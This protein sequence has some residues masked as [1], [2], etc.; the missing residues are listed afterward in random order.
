MNAFNMILTP[1]IAD[2]YHKKNYKQLE[3][4]FRVNTKWGIYCVIPLVL[5]IMFA[6]GDIMT[7]LFGSEYS[8]GAVALQI[9][10]IG[11]FINIATGA[12]GIMLIMTGHQQEWFRLSVLIVI[13]NIILNL[14]LIPR[15]GIEGTAIAT[16]ST[17][18]GLFAL[19]LLIVRHTLHMWPYDRRY[20]KGLV[21]AGATVVALLLIA[22][23]PLSPLLNV[24]ISTA[25]SGIVFVGVLLLQGLD[26]E[27]KAFINLIRKR[28]RPT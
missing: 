1:M 13:V 22:T 5:L 17:V 20:I 21:A 10:T 16:A 23:L 7:V 8:G 15:F 4:L 14:T 19:G 6:A 2:Q 27:D 26:S 25:A 24:I 18:G 3:E 28:V 9:L 12:T 11:Q